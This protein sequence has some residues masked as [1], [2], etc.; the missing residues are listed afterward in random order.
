MTDY[1]GLILDD[2][3]EGA[4]DHAISQLEATL[5]AALPADYQQFLKA[6]NGAYVPYDVQVTLASGEQ[7][8]LSF[9]LYALALDEQYEANPFE[10]AQLRDDPDFPASG[11][12]PIGRDGGASL[13]FLD[14]REGRQTVGALVAAL[15]AW[16]GR[17]Q[18]EDEYVVLADS[19]TGFLDALFLSHER[20]HSHIE[21]FII[22]AQSI[23]A[24]LEW[25]DKGRPGWREEYREQWN[26]RVVDAPI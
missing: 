7:D 5:G 4:T 20:I 3:R 12:L 13:L 16:T 8:L 18:G 15:P 11:L 14:L 10:L 2:T 22:S 23:E 17:R 21:R 6:C 26:A 25:L 1:H 24:T 19:F 9:S